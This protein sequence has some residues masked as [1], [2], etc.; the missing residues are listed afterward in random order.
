MRLTH[1][2]LAGFKSFVDPTHVP[3]PGQIV[4]IVGP[5]G[6]GKSNVID[7][8]RWVLG[9]SSARHLRGETMQDVIFS[10]AGERKPAGR[11]SVEMHFDNSLGKAGGAW[12]Q[13]GEIVVKRVLQRDGDSSYYINNLHVRRR[14]VADIFL[15]T[16]LGGRAYAIIEQGTIS[17]IVE[18]KPEEIRIFLEEAA[19][20]SKYRERRRETELRLADTRTNLNRV[21]DILRELAA[22][23]EHLAAQAETAQ[24]YQALQAELA[25]TRQ[26]LWYVRKQ[27][28]GNQRARLQRELERVSVELEAE[29]ARLRAA[30]RRAEQLRTEHYAAGDALH[31]AQGELY[32]T[33]AEVARV[34]QELA[35][36]RDNCQRTDQRIASVRLRIGQGSR[37][38]EAIGGAQREAAEKL[39]AAGSA[40]AAAREYAEHVC[41]ELPAAESAFRTGQTAVEESARA[42][43]AAEQTWRVEDTRREHAAKLLAQHGERRARLLEER[44]R[45]AH[46]QAEVIAE[47]ESRIARLD[48]TLEQAR[49]VAAAEEASLPER[50]QAAREAAGRLDEATQERARI[51]ARLQALEQ[52]QARVGNGQQLGPWRARHGIDSL[53]RLWQGIDIEDGWEDALESVLRERLDAVE[54]DEVNHAAG[55][56]ADPPPG[57]IALFGAR[58][59]AVAHF[60]APD[61]GLPRLLDYVRCKSE[62]CRPL[63]E[64]WL[65]RV[66]VVDDAAAAFAARECLEPGEL[67]VARSGHLFTRH[68]V[69]FHAP[70]SELHGVLG[71]QRE[72]EQLRGA[73]A[74]AGELLAARKSGR[75]QADDALRLAREALQAARKRLE[76][77]RQEGHGLQLEH[78]KL[79]EQADRVRSRD[80]QIGR[81]LEELDQQ[82]ATEQS[83]GEAAAANVARFSEV[84]GV[85]RSQLT[86]ARARFTQAD[87]ALAA[88]R[89]AVQGAERQLQESEY[90]HKT[91]AARLDELAAQQRLLEEQVA[92]ETASLAELEAERA[93]FDEAPLAEKL[94][95]MLGVRALREQRV[96]EARQAVETVEGDLKSAEEERLASEQKLDPLRERI[97]DVRLK[98]QEARLNE[99]S[100]QQQLTEAG[101]DQTEL[102]GLVEKGVRSGALASEITRLE[103]EI[104]A[105]GAV[106]L[107]AVEELDAATQR[108]QYLETQSA[109]LT[110]AMATLEAAIR[111]IDRESRERLMA[112]FE[113]VN[114][115]LAEMFPALFGGGQARLVLTGDEILDS[116]VQLI[117][118]PPGK[119]NTSIHLLSGGEKALSALAL[120][121]SLFLLNPAPFCLLD[122]VDAP[123][124]DTNTERFCGLLK[125]MASHTQFIVIS[126]NKIT[127]EVAEQLVGVTMQEL[128]VSRVVAVDV[129]E[130]LRMQEEATA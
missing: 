62:A 34:E 26:L 20:V 98:E 92:R 122:E 57:K 3:L 78:L 83:E 60:A 75:E 121:F 46:P 36:V 73:A 80:A 24:R 119:R 55:W 66:Y 31:A 69:V 25:R 38:Q 48:E 112:T 90:Q 68:G 72:I 39:A 114:L 91:C 77:A 111:R 110:E 53:P 87:A 44:G 127:M 65:A 130:A 123:L 19:G 99:E 4:G 61:R 106:N 103:E 54:I 126:H 81:E 79:A 117:A 27:E 29:T 104:A 51:A 17:R 1:L 49:V 85:A 105:L 82:I 33:N 93:T 128:G 64:E 43:A 45:L 116:G 41:I 129:E 118:Q 102:A 74:Q 120:V 67:I 95:Q 63:L 10:G 109:D 40:V 30:E 115:H 113:Q 9:E 8:V 94:Q 23:L 15:G 76:M 107:A 58:T 96:G 52:L 88:Q 101:A 2:K 47:L 18:A 12:S 59:S 22:Q 13:Y 86:D 124:D 97:N 14:D 50:E 28:I 100:L 71:R 84:L 37:Q 5:N 35:F 6:C 56:L 70:E 32:E 89:G 21:E 108:K 42:V 7:A 11:A 16:G 125:K